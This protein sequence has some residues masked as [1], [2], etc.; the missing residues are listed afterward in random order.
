MLIID[1]NLS[2]C[3]Q[4]LIYL[5]LSITNEC[6]QIKINEESNDTNEIDVYQE[7]LENEGGKIILILLKLLYSVQVNSIKTILINWQLKLVKYLLLCYRFFIYFQECLSPLLAEN[8]KLCFTRS[9]MILPKAMRCCYAQT[10]LLNTFVTQPTKA[11]PLSFQIYICCRSSS[12]K[13]LILSQMW[14]VPF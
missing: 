6:V 12:R 14:L 4:L 10:Y 3:Y 11:L 13:L 8:L 7:L 1:K 9:L 2:L 5:I